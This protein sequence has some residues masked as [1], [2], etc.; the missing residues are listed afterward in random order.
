MGDARRW[1]GAGGGRAPAPK[2][3]GTPVIGLPSKTLFTTL[4]Y[5]RVASALRKATV[6]PLEQGSPHLH[7]LSDRQ[8]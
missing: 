3:A 7:P 4:S 2:T 5:K 8:E 6:Q 1:Q